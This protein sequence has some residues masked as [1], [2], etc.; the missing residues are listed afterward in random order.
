MTRS[1]A[2]DCLLVPIANPETVDRLIDTAINIARGQNRSIR[3]FNVVEVPSQLPLDAGAEVVSK[4]VE[5]LLDYARSRGEA[6]DVPLETSR[7]Y[8]RDVATGIVGAVDAYDGGAMLLGWRGRPRRRDIILG[9]FID[10]VLGEAECDVYVKRIKLPSRAVESILVPIAGGPHDAL[11]AELAGVLATQH[12]ASVV[13]MHVAA[14]EMSDA[15][16]AE[17]SS[18]LDDRQARLP[19]GI[20][21]ERMLLEQ[22]TVAGAITDATV[23]HDLTILG[24]TTEARLGRRLVGAVAED[25]GRTAAGSVIVTRKNID[26]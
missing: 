19:G 23:D 26:P 14:G 9:S 5:E 18:L 7:R 1:A 16:H 10:R 21:V 17:V 15:R 13:L 4:E 6:A 2:E 20:S 11:A 3:M 24:A 12:E 25:V 8:A 22:P